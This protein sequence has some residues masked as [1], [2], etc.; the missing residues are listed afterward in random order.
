MQNTPFHATGPLR[1]KLL[2]IHDRD[3]WYYKFSLTVC[4]LIVK[5]EVELLP[6]D[7]VDLMLMSVVNVDV[8]RSSIGTFSILLTFK[9][10]VA[11]LAE[12]CLCESH[13][14]H[15]YITYKNDYLCYCLLTLI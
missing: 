2:V 7:Y 14:S 13:C 6:I 1:V 8:C 5:V 15:E 12:R 4:V 11:E 10:F 9:L 3:L